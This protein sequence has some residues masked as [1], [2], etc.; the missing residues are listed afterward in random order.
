MNT[1]TKQNQIS[2]FISP[3]IYRDGVII[4]KLKP[5]IH[6]LAGVYVI[7]IKDTTNDKKVKTEKKSKSAKEIKN[8]LKSL[9]GSLAD[10]E[11]FKGKTSV[12]VQ[13]YITKYLW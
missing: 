8:L 11:E 4:P 12:E 3:A 10:V 9:Q 6:Q 5:S 2:T 1:I 13:H 7:F